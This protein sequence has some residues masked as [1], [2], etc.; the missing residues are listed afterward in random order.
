MQLCVNEKKP[1]NIIVVQGY[2]ARGEP[3]GKYRCQ[4]SSDAHARSLILVTGCRRND[5]KEQ[6]TARETNIL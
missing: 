4:T 5:D 3:R 6:D 2:P 1:R